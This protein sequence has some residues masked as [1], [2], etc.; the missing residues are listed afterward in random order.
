MYALRDGSMSKTQEW[1]RCCEVDPPSLTCCAAR[2]ST[3]YSK[4]KEIHVHTSA[5]GGCQRKKPVPG[6]K[7]PRC[8]EWGKEQRE[9]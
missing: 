5:G 9:K 6:L 2:A 7:E 1:W 4:I 8:G 3:G